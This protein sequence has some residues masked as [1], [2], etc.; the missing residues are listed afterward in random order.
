MKCDL[1]GKKA[2]V[3][4]SSRG[5]GSAI[6][7]EL[8]QGGA[9]IFLHYAGNRQSA[10]KMKEEIENIGGKA[11]IVQADL[12]DNTSYEHLAK[13]VGDIDIL[14]LNASMQF[15]NKWENITQDNK[16]TIFDYLIIMNEM[17]EKFDL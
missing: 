10:E 13:E 16:K 17:V 6:A 7:L 1:T 14:I 9:E 2:L 4:G 11:T 8:A 3:T 12:S 5:I 15:K